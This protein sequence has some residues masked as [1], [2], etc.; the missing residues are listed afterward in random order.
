MV[1]I[2][3]TAKNPH[4]FGVIGIRIQNFI[5]YAGTFTKFSHLADF[6]AIGKKATRL[7]LYGHVS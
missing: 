4:T 1:K 5:S 2:F 6:V 3:G 7:A